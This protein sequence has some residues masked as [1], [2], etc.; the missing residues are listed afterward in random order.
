MFQEIFKHTKFA[1]GLSAGLWLT[2]CV[3]IDLETGFLSNEDINRQILDQTEEA[4]PELDP[5]YISDEIKRLVD[6]NLNSRSSDRV[7]VNKLQEHLYDE[8]YLHIQYSDVRTHTAMEAF[9]TREGNCLS[10][11]NLYIAMARYAGVDAEFQTVNVQP[12]W[13]RRGSLLVLSQHINATGRLSVN[14]YYVVDFTPEIALQKLTSRS[15]TDQEA[16]AL[17]F[18]N[19]GAEALIAERID[20]ALVYFKNALFLNPTLSIAWNNIGT[21]YKHQGNT[22]FAEYSYQMAFNTD[23]TNATSINNLA[24]FYRGTGNARLAREYEI[25]IQRFNNLNPY[26]HYAQGAVAM[27]NRDYESARKSFRRALLLKE[28]E[29]DFHIGLARA[30]VA[31]GNTREAEKLR[32]SAE[33]LLAENQ[34][35]YQPSDQKVRIINNDSILRNSSPGI[36]ILLN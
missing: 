30:H 22:A 8:E 10:V 5:L 20:D 25:A 11:M 23:N 32:D 24:K 6:D 34:Q 1:T 13:D 28:V 7:K 29:P 15:I 18:N 21:T 12:S 2:A 14:S 17:Y 3:S 33:K 16:R 19:L 36:S 9:Q 35:I 26:Y 4:F 31:L 27:R